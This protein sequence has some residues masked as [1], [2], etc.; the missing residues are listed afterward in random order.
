[1]VV[2]LGPGRFYGSSLPRPRFFPGDR[3]DPLPSVTEP[4]L[5]WAQ[6]AHWSMG[7]L[8]VKRLRLQG[9]IEGSP[10]RSPRSDDGASDGDSDE[11]EAVVQERILKREVVDDDEDSDGSDQSEEEDDESLATI[12]TAS[13]RKRA[14][15]LSDEFDRI[16]AQQELEKKQKA[17]A[18]ARAAAGAVGGGG[19]R[20]ALREPERMRVWQVAAAGPAGAQAA[21]GVGA[22]GVESGGGWSKGARRRR[23][24]PAASCAGGRATAGGRSFSARWGWMRQTVVD[25]ERERIERKGKKK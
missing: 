22:V 21:V 16:A 15:K 14:R 8:G 3:V 13:K 23:A 18:G 4:L 2:A 19:R 17:A 7:G 12:A 10:R 5:A 24:G 9:R 1:M 6:E 25:K 11:E 20:P